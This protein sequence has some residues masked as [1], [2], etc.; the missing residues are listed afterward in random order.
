MPSRDDDLRQTYGAIADPLA[1]LHGLFE[2]SPV[3]YAV[4]LLDGHCLLTNPAYRAMFGRAPPPEY[5]IFED[6]VAEALGLTP[7][8]R[9]A[10]D[11]E[12]VHTPTF[13]YDPAALEHVE[14]RG[15]RRAAIAC[16]LFPLRTAGAVAQV[17]IAYKDVTAELNAQAA[18]ERERDVLRTIVQQSGD[19][20]VVADET[21][22]MTLLNPEAERQHGVRLKAVG[23][24]E[25]AAAYGLQT[26]DGGPLPVAETPLYRALHGERVDGGRWIVVRPD[27]E[28]RLLVGTATPLRRA[29]G[30]N[31]GAVL[32]TRDETE[33]T[34]ADEALRRSEARYR[35]LLEAP[36]AI[37]WTCTPAG[38]FAD[39]Q[40]AWTRFTGQGPEAS[41]GW[42]WMDAVH[43]AD[44]DRIR[45]AW[46][47]VVET[48]ASVYQETC[49]LRR[50]DGAWRLAEI[51]AVAA[52]DPDGQVREWVG[53]TND[54]TDRDAAESL[55][56]HVMRSQVA[57][58][59]IT[60]T[61]GTV[62]QAN[63][64]LLQI[65][66][67]TR[68]ELVTE[69]V[70]WQTVTP[71]EWL[72]TDLRAVE[73]FKAKGSVTPYEKEYVRKDGT[74]VPVLLGV[75]PLPGEGEKV[76]TFVL[77]IT[78]VSRARMRHRFLA[79]ASGVLAASLDYDETLCAVGQLTVPSLADWCFI[80][81]VE[82]DGSVR[83]VAAVNADPADGEL[84]ERARQFSILAG[85]AKEH[86]ATNALMSGR[87][88]LIS[89]MSEEQRRRMAIDEQHM[90]IMADIGP[91]SLMSI[92]LTARGRTAGVLTLVMTQS[93]R[94]YDEVDLATAEDLARRVALATDNARLYGEAQSAV[95]LRDEFL[96]IASHELRTPLT[97]LQMQ[98]ENIARKLPTLMKDAQ[99]EAWVDKRITSVRRHCDRLNRLIDELLDV[100]HIARGDLRLD[101][102][103]VDLVKIVRE[104]VRGFEAQARLAGTPW[105]V[106]VKESGPVV[107]RWDG[108]RIQQIVTNLVSNAVKYGASEPVRITV[109][110]DSA[111]ATLEVEDHGIGIP[112]EAHQRIFGRFER[113]VSARHFGGLGLGL[114]V[115]RQ[116][117]E[118][119]GGTIGV[120]S[121][122]AEGARFVVQ[123][124]LLVAEPAAPGAELPGR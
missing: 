102:E 62:H 4:F 77:D 3:P 44:R 63:D 108:L 122:P 21:G 7:L 87:S 30:S 56:E 8:L 2:H 82:K 26:V 64:T 19:G 53:I 107:G 70:R 112:T 92:P 91:R 36:T 85:A 50:H 124:P 32:I 76:V 57:G 58:I 39:E 43:P 94:R 54:V 103:P 1:L 9:R 104:V 60:D 17:A 100:S 80:D 25:W 27:G 89:D 86:P 16:T 51:R 90:E 24:T 49:R 119:M 13:W 68:E 6:E 42:G 71:P 12:T 105:L 106:E 29:D 67:Y 115:A 37:I 74:R 22:T 96:S 33:R 41:H 61:A 118:A 93:G 88:V 66:G 59:V 38:A 34:R 111:T 28:R 114:Y 55:L 52:R 109:A 98:V 73:E 5:S 113:A 47:A 20:I 35:S 84:A 65:L 14:V 120:I 97:P 46:S 15:S 48:Q 110:T 83:R 101:V 75:A 72:H 78:E 40:P 99:S 123:L 81:V 23:P 121:Q 31:A 79:D 45:R 11:G 18:A 95:R 117:V 10:F 69:Q 116:L